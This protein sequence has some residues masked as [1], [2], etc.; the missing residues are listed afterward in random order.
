[1]RLHRVNITPHKGG[2]LYEIVLI[3]DN[4]SEYI[5][6]F[7]QPRIGDDYLRTAINHFTHYQEE[8]KRVYLGDAA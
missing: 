6:K 2:Y 8:V 3:D 4:G 1:M 5:Q 7:V